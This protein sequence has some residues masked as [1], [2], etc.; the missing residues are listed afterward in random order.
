[1]SRASSID[2]N[3]IREALRVCRNKRSGTPKS[4][5]SIASDIDANTDVLIDHKRLSKCV[6]GEWERSAKRRQQGHR[7]SRD[8]NEEELEA[9]LDFFSN[10]DSEG[11]LGARENFLEAPIE[12]LV[13]LQMAEY[14]AL[15]GNETRFLTMEHL[16]GLYIANRSDKTVEL[17]FHRSEVT[18][19][20]D[21]TLT[22]MPSSA[23]Q[24]VHLFYGWGVVSPEDNVLLFL[25]DAES[26]ENRTLT[27]TA[28]DNRIYRDRS[29]NALVMF[30]N[31][32]PLDTHS[33][34]IPLDAHTLGASIE[35]ELTSHHIV[36]VRSDIILDSP[37]KG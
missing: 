14:L 7:K 21:V 20:T 9:L 29:P 17:R 23:A 37:E 6:D 34:E 25:K 8:F 18:H 2:S 19:A 11:Y 30:D 26:K 24:P 31:S 36:F 12:E 10:P 1:M 3:R 35:G 15:E 13:P 22:E 28:I 5:F 4:W 27:T 32:S 16:E 33:V